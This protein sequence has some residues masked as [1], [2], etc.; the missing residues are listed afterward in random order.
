MSPRWT[1][2]LLLVARERILR[3]DDKGRV[4]GEQ[5]VNSKDAQACAVG[6]QAMLAKPQPM[7]LHRL[8][9]VL[10]APWSQCLLLPWQPLA[11]H[12]DWESYC[13]SRMSG[14]TGTHLLEGWRLSADDAGWQRNRLVEAAPE[15][16]C[17]SIAKACKKRG[18]W[19]TGIQSLFVAAMNVHRRAMVGGDAACVVVDEGTLHIGFRHRGDWSGCMSL[20]GSVSSLAFA[21]RDAAMVCGLSVPEQSYVIGPASASHELHLPASQW[22]PLPWMARRAHA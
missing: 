6:I 14:Q 5:T 18:V 15:S 13:R 16:L 17:T 9:I 3:F 4:L 12:G 22:L 21:L 10:A 20:P 2:T 11:Q 19:L 1:N 7:G 8:R